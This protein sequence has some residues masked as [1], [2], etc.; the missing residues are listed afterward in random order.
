MKKQKIIKWIDAKKRSPRHRQVVLAKYEG[1]YTNR[2]VTFWK[3]AGGGK[4]YGDP[5]C[6][7]PV[8]HWALLPK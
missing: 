5:P 4:H 2:V 8:T 3:D 6:S 1:V 7:N